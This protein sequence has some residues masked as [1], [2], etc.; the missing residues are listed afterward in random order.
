MGAS[1]LLWSN[2][3][4][5]EENGR[6]WER[7]F[8]YFLIF[9]CFFN[10]FL[11]KIGPRACGIHSWTFWQSLSVFRQL[12]THFETILHFCFFL[13]K[14]R[15]IVWR[16]F[17]V[18][19]IFSC[20]FELRRLRD[21]SQIV[22]LVFAVR[23]V[24]SRASETSKTPHSWQNNVPKRSTKK[25]GA[26]TKSQPLPLGRKSLN[27]LRS[28]SSLVK[29]AGSIWFLNDFEPGVPKFKQFTNSLFKYFL[30]FWGG[31]DF[32]FVQR[33]IV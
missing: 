23:T 5:N 11:A 4:K 24:A 9:P 14:K 18:F 8:W 2:P 21:Q 30:F 12:P 27:N 15:F 28:Q 32:L 7:C 17:K 20:F 25:I 26:K 22:D 13:K 16:I 19:L 1:I 6:K 31:C 33:K 3:R 10:D 29:F